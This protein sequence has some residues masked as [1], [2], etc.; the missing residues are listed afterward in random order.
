MKNAPPPPSQEVPSGS[1]PSE[2]APSAS[3]P[4]QPGP[5][6]T[7]PDAP[8]LPGR[9]RLGWPALLVVWVFWGGTYLGIRIADQ[10]IPPLLLAGSRYLIAGILLLP[11]GLRSGSP[12]DR[13]SDRP[14]A[15]QWLSAAAVGVLMLAIGNGGVTVAERRIPSGLAALLVATVPL[16]LVVLDRFVNHRPVRPPVLLGLLAGLAGVGLL[17]G[18]ISIGAQAVPGPGAATG[19]V[20]VLAASAAWALGTVLAGKLAIPV[21]PMLATAMQMLIGGAVLLG[22][23]AVSGEFRHFYPG[24]VSVSSWV[25]LAYL[26]GPGS[27]LAFT[28]YGIAVRSL[29]TATVSTYAYVNPVV[30]VFLGA[31]VLAEPVTPGILAGGGFIVVAVAVILRY[32]NGSPH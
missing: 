1:A 16:W 17:S 9:Y 28:A 24:Q 4:G 23:A 26:I 22:G 29:S 30:A 27:I 10:T 8:R 6:E 5:S 12:Q 13:V 15:R 14:R 25:A 32:R 2:S 19:T 21:R 11:F 31:L 3:G 7:S 18:V 20:I